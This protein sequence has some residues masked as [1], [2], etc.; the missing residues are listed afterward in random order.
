[1]SCSAGHHR[2]E[3]CSHR[4]TFSVALTPRRV[5]QGQGIH[6]G[7][8]T[9]LLLSCR[10]TT[11]LA[12]LLPVKICRPFNDR[13]VR[14]DLRFTSRKLSSAAVPTLDS[15]VTRHVAEQAGGE[16][17]KAVLQEAYTVPRARHCMSHSWTSSRRIAVATK[18]HYLDQDKRIWLTQSSILTM[19]SLPTH[20]DRG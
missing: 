19:A 11:F 3:Q 6:A 16:L 10:L 9:V 12:V 20:S 17:N 8:L 1:M 4:F 5:Y 14:T 15:A 18:K 13:P 2:R 7:L